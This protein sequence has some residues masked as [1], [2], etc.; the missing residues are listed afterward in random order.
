MPSESLPIYNIYQQTIGTDGNLWLATSY[1]G[2]FRFDGSHWTNYDTT[3]GLISMNVR[4]IECDSHGAIW[5][6]CGG[7]GL[8]K[9]DGTTWKKL[10]MPGG[11]RNN[12]VDDL[13][14]DGD[15]NVWCAAYPGAYV[16]NG[17]SWSSFG[18][19]DG[20]VRVI[21]IDRSGIKWFGSLYGLNSYDGVQIE[22]YTIS[23]EPLNNG[24]AAIAVD[25]TGCRWFG[26]PQGITRYNGTSWT[27][28]DTSDGLAYGN[29]ISIA[30]DRSNTVWCGDNIGAVNRFNGTSWEPLMSSFNNS[31]LLLSETGRIKTIS[32]DNLGNKW[33]GFNSSGFRAVL[34][35]YNDTVFTRYD[36]IGTIPLR[37]I[38]I[39]DMLFEKNSTM[40]LA[41]SDGAI[42][43]DGTTST[44]YTERDGLAANNLKGVDID[45]NGNIWFASYVGGVSMLIASSLAVDREMVTR[46]HRNN[47]ISV[48]VC[49]LTT[50]TTQ[51]LLDKITPIQMSLYDLTG[52]ML[53]NCTT[54][55][56]PGLNNF[57][58]NTRDVANGKYLLIIDI[59][60]FSKTEKIVL[61]R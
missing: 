11:L 12:Y 20:S 49:N 31:S 28:F 24:V 23:N 30:V 59:E 47:N 51:C 44:F 17:K 35:K 54:L 15:G 39:A 19:A 61:M 1:N 52:R 53:K 26:T 56:K 37:N 55:G 46:L 45:K 43:F 14:I 32:I 60:G 5:A 38:E 3:N 9:F 48:V 34:V 6:G 7:N 18:V 4:S 41:T 58:L 50:V 2:V 33:F 21:A 57:T 10:T 42:C 27:S 13:I 29:I 22:N 40:W 36:T 16:F 25:S 8:Q